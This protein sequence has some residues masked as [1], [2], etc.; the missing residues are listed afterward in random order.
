MELSNSTLQQFSEVMNFTSNQIQAMMGVGQSNGTTNS[1]VYRNKAQVEQSDN[2][3]SL[4][5]AQV[6]AILEQAIRQY[7]LTALDLYLRTDCIR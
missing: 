1:S 6:T 2:L 5:S 3:R 4:G 7:A